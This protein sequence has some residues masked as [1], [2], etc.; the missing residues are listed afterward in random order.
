MLRAVERFEQAL[1]MAVR[2]TNT[3]GR[4]ALMIGSGQV[5][6]TGKLEKEVL[7]DSP[8]EVPCSL[9]RELLVGIKS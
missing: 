1:Q 7:W 6:L 2:L 4:V 8:V 5:E 9:S 3:G